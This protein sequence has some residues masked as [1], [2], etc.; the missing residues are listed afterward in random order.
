[1]IA[2]IILT[3]RDKECKLFLCLE[4]FIENLN[5]GLYVY[6]NIENETL[7][8]ILLNKEKKLIVIDYLSYM[9]ETIDI[10]KKI[11]AL[12]KNACLVVTNAPEEVN[13]AMQYLKEGVSYYF[14]K[15]LSEECFCNL[16]NEIMGYKLISLNERNKVL[17]S[18]IGESQE[19]KRI[20]EYIPTIAETN[21]NVL[22]I[23]ETGTGKECLARIIHK[24][25]PRRTGPFIVLD[26]TLLQETIFESEVFGYE[27]GAFTG[28][29]ATKKGLVELADGGTLFI[30]EVGELPLSLQKKFLR[31]VQEKTFMRV[32]GTKFLKSDARIIS[33]TN[34]NL[35]E[36]VKRGN[37]RADLYFRLN[38]IVI[39]IPP[40]RE[41]KEDIPLLFEHFINIKS[42]ELGKSFKGFSKGFFQI[43]LDYSWPG[44]VRELINVIER[45]LVLS[46]D[47][48]LSEEV[49]NFLSVK[50]SKASIIKEG[51]LDDTSRDERFYNAKSV[52]LLDLEREVILDA[53]RKNN[54]NQTKTAEY[55]GISRKQWINKMKK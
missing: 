32:G 24:L 18:F 54:F 55:L 37:F 11:R 40:L 13:F 2:I 31:F 45:A 46:P 15:E 51:F 19:I 50:G 34:K 8:S 9:E 38:T 20:K 44:N 28:A 49:L 36:E 35:E 52:K 3:K 1:M 21:C 23:G 6:D 10:I 14:T 17:D 48:Y 39:K 41:R 22:I 42:K 16:L 27:K 33:A 25:S 7:F 5:V 53:L 30:D 26:C 43:L 29:F 47:G 4:H 12:V